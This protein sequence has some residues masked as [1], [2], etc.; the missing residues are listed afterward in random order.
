MLMEVQL[1]QGIPWLIGRI[2]EFVSGGIV[3]VNIWFFIGFAEKLYI[4]RRRQL[5][6]ATKKICDYCQSENVLNAWY[7][8][9]CGSALQVAASYEKMHVTPYRGLERLSNAFNFMSWLAATSG[10]L[11]AIVIFISFLFSNVLFGIF[12]SLIAGLIVYMVAILFKAASDT[13]RMG[14]NISDKL[15]PK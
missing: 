5:L 14:I 4:F 13:I 12:G 9:K 11:V 3:G 10:I 2:F 15:N 7:C 6:E 8:A 1:N